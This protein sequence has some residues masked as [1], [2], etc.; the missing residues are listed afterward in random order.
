M[1]RI[2]KDLDL[3]EI[4]GKSTTQI[5]VGQYDVQFTFGE[6]DFLVESKACIYCKGELIG[7]WSGG[8]WPSSGFYKIMNVDVVRY[9]I[10]NDRTIVI[11]L[12]GGIEIHLFDDSDQ[13]E[14]LQIS[15]PGQL[16]P[17]II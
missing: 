15:I 11:H 10:P 6:V 7:E 9:E 12:D 13:F 14:C 4:I 2:P 5:R 8:N 17:W 1:Y 3:S 16:G